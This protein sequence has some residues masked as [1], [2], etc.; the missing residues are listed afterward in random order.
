M[1]LRAMFK[2]VCGCCVWVVPSNSHSHTHTKPPIS[3]LT[4]SLNP[5][6]PHCREYEGETLSDV[7][8][9]SIGQMGPGV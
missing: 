2:H 3:H 9:V 8:G 7:L 5:T 1:V 6:G 4:P